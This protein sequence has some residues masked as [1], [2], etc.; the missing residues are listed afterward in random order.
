M[1]SLAQARISLLQLYYHDKPIYNMSFDIN[2]KGDL[3]IDLLNK[4]LNYLLI[5]YPELRT[6]VL[7]ENDQIVKKYNS[8][9]FSMQ[10]NYEN[11]PLAE[12]NFIN[13]PFDISSDLLIKVLYLKNSN[14]MIFLFSDII[15]DGFTILIFFKELQYIYNC[16]FNCIIP[17]YKNIS[18]P[19][20][21]LNENNLMFWKNLLN[22]SNQFQI[23][24]KTNTN[25]FDENRIHFNITNKN[26]IFIKSNL[27]KIT[28]FDYFTSTFN[29]LL[30]IMTRQN[31]ITIDTLLGGYNE[32]NIGLFN[33]IA[34][35][36]SNFNSLHIS[37]SKFRELQS[38]M[39]LDIKEK[40]I[41]LEFLANKLEFNDLPNIR[42]HFE[43]SNKNTDKSLK[44]GDSILESNLYENSSN[45]IRQLLTLNICEFKN[46]IE[47]YFSYKKECFDEKYINLLIEIYNELLICRNYSLNDIISKYQIQNY[48]STIY[49][50]KIDK[51]LISYS[52]AGNYPNIK[53]SEFKNILDKIN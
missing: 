35:I 52:F 19:I 32:N 1:L 24:V 38:K 44:F 46:K 8:N 12:Y 13:N 31:Q 21:N 40:K 15:I 18:P 42:I 17:N 11:N 36:P 33:D 27:H 25:T 4:S 49:N 45:Q 22:R 34:L 10:I 29:L 6:N 5:R 48:Y 43:Y 39:L 3:S 47:C 41:S 51:R 30:F 20:I 50:E 37:L 23:N 7:L 9:E 26:L 14:K 16:L 2:V 53:Y 28:L